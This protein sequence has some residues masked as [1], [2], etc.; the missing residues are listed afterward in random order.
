MDDDYYRESVDVLRRNAGRR[1]IDRRI[2]SGIT[3]GD[4]METLKTAN[5]L[6]INPRT[7]EEM[8]N[9]L[10]SDKVTPLHG[11]V[12][13]F[14]YGCIH[15]QEDLSPEC[16]PSCIRGFAYHTVP[17]CNIPIYEYQKNTLKMIRNVRGISVYV[18]SDVAPDTNMVD[19]LRKER[20]KKASIYMRVG[21]GISYKYHGT[22]HI[23][24][25]DATYKAHINEN[26]K[27]F[28]SSRTVC[29]PTKNEQTE[30]ATD[31][32]TN[33]WIMV[34]VAFV[35]VSILMIVYKDRIG[36][37]KDVIKS[38]VE[39]ATNDSEWMG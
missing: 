35:I 15:E 7:E 34:V 16:T 25:R 10:R 11:T 14:L 12:G 6:L 24:K 1:S 33:T 19:S 21:S 23:K 18:F 38:E 8:E 20:V 2:S 36:S 39:V 5:K 29:D 26:N 9:L 17:D 37:R 3:Y 31:S 13:E 22:L 4:E 32:S 28:E 30:C 27:K